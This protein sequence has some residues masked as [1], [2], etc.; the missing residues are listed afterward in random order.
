MTRPLQPVL[1]DRRRVALALVLTAAAPA[2]LAKPC[3][4]PQVLFVCPFGTVK[5]AIARERLKQRAAARHVAVAV[6]SRGVHPADHVSPLL[7]SRLAADGIDPKSEPV[8]TLEAPDIAGADVVVVF[9]EAAQAPG[10]T[11]ARVWDVPSWSDYAA[12]KAALDPKIEALL[13][14]L[15]GRPCTS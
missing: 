3:A 10:L 11:R 15:A 5:S 2:A 12:A 7:A 9:D 14:E 13:D 1:I 8:R 6:Q 4:P